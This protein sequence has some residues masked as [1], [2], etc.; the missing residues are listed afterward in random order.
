MKQVRKLI[1]SDE[2]QARICTAC[3]LKKCNQMANLRCA[4]L[5][6]NQRAIAERI[7]SNRDTARRLR[8]LR[9]QQRGYQP[10][11]HGALEKPIRRG[12]WPDMHGELK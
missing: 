4:L 5:R 6:E 1:L 9:V 3:P 8:T 10:H 7:S 2:E 12:Y 11:R